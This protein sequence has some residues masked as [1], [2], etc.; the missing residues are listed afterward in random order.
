[1]IGGDKISTVKSISIK[2]IS[3]IGFLLKLN[4]VAFTNYQI[5]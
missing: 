5:K 4:F 2:K 3:K 1:M